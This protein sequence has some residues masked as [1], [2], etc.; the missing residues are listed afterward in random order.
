MHS[1]TRRYK[2]AAAA[3]WWRRELKLKPKF[4][5]GSSYV[6]LQALSSRRF[7]MGFICSSRTA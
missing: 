5:N 3:E 2:P 7:Q 1:P 6:K 4:E